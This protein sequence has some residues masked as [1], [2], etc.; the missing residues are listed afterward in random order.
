M[1]AISRAVLADPPILILD[2]ATSNIDT[3]TEMH[4][5][6]VM[7][8]LMHGRTTFVI[9]HRLGTIRDADVIMVVEG[10]HIVERGTHDELMAM[11]GF[12]YKMYTAQMGIADVEAQAQMQLAANDIDIY[13]NV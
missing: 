3:R 7:A 2:E 9:A 6:K 5:Q 1:L 8:D 13:A 11:G 10:G 12:Y 4:I